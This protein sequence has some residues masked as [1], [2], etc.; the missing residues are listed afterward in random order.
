MPVI[1]TNFFNTLKDM[2]K[3]REKFAEVKDSFSSVQEV[4]FSGGGLVKVKLSGNMA[5]ISVEIDPS[6]L[7]AKD[8]QM[9]QDLIVAAHA[10]ATEKIDEV[11]RER[12][13][14]LSEQIKGL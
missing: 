14:P 2:D 10:N 8:V 12:L 9:L 1:M 13:G 4:G 7:E 11:M 3:I 5:L 6:L